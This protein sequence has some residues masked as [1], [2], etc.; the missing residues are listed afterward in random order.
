[1]RRWIWTLGLT[2]AGVW[3]AEALM[4]QEKNVRQKDTITSKI[5]EFAD[6]YGELMFYSEE[7]GPLFSWEELNMLPAYDSTADSWLR[8][9]VRL[10][11]P[12]Q[13]DPF[14]L[15]ELLRRGRQLV[16][17]RAKGKSGESWNPNATLFYRFSAANRLQ[18]GITLDHDA[19]EPLFDK[20]IWIDFVS[21]HLQLSRI[22][23]WKRIVAGDYTVRFGQG[24][25]AWNG[26][27]MS[28]LGPVQ[29]LRRSE[30]GLTAYTGSN[31]DIFFRGLGATYERGR[32]QATLFGSAKKVDARITSDGFTSLLHTGLHR[33]ATELERRHNLS[34]AIA[35]VNISLRGDWIKI[36]GTALG[37]AYD[38]RNAATLRPDN[39]YQSRRLPFGSAS[40]DGLAVWGDWRLFGEW[41]VD[42]RAQMAGLFGVLWDGG[43]GLEAGILYRNYGKGYTAPFSG[44]YSRNSKAFNEH[45]ITGSFEYAWRRWRLLFSGEWCYFPWLRYNVASSSH[46]RSAMMQ[47]DRNIGRNT[48]CY[49]KIDYKHSETGSR[50]PLTRNDRYGFRLHAQYGSGGAW[51]FS[52]RLEYCLLQSSGPNPLS[53]GAALLSD[54][55]YTPPSLALSGSGRMAIFRTKDWA[56]RI[57]AY[58]RDAMQGFSFPPL[59]GYGVRGYLNLRYTLNR[60]LDFW[61]RGAA[62]RY[63]SAKHPSASAPVGRSLWEL[64]VKF[65]FRVSW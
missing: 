9:Y 58:E 59:Y 37:Y 62:T 12:G 50:L 34:E 5:E 27:S 16:L 20:G 10:W 35:G 7:Y 19:G 14:K 43:D 38:H 30:M 46:A 2:A 21:F 64:D 3:C 31:E 1:M 56:T 33:T 29:S 8:P 13:A 54:V 63:L 53:G 26:F 23:S 28:G 22:G 42:G 17:F 15:G 61:L 39:R 51:L 57:Y 47:I 55:V 6:L 18:W 48:L 52:H 40:I 11:R 45:A 25:V 32:M 65:Q 36:G 49:A 24:L 4:A 41:A 44:A 60:N